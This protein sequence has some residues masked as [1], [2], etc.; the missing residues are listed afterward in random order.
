MV[1]LAAREAAATEV[2]DYPESGAEVLR[3]SGASG[4]AVGQGPE[5]ALVAETEF[6]EIFYSRHGAFGQQWVEEGGGARGLD[7]LLPST[8]LRGA[9]LCEWHSGAST[10]LALSGE[11]AAQVLPD[12]V[13]ALAAPRGCRVVLELLG[14]SAR[15]AIVSVSL[16]PSLCGRVGSVWCAPLPTVL[17]RSR[18]AMRRRACLVGVSGGTPDVCP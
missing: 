7:P 5:G 14:G 10:H 8:P 12:V 9:S 2:A 15:E 6:R 13:R 4:A 1:A 16:Q 18:R 11:T 3:R 17:Q